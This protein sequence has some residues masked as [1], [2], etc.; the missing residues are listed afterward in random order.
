VIDKISQHNNVNKKK[1]MSRYTDLLTNVQGWTHFPKYDVITTHERHMIA[2]IKT[3]VLILSLTCFFYK[4]EADFM[5]SI[6]RK[7]K[8][9]LLILLNPLN[10]FY[11]PML[12]NAALIF[13][14]KT[15]FFKTS[16]AY[17]LTN[18]QSRETDNIGYTR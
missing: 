17:F 5:R 13:R 2:M 18:E 15:G 1:T 9:P 8:Q 11:K 12:H 10:I 6:F 7:R 14:I 16:T 3:T 4:Y